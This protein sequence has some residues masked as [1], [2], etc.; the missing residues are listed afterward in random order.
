MRSLRRPPRRLR[1]L[2]AVVGLVHLLVP[3]LLLDTARWAYARVLAVE[4]E[5]RDGAPRRVRLVGI[6]FV[7]VA[8]LVPGRGRTRRRTR[9]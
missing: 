7:C 3:G 6:A 8:V 5:P 2:F 1:A 9:E 4:F